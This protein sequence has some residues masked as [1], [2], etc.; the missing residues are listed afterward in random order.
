MAQFDWRSNSEEEAFR[1]LCSQNLVGACLL[2]LIF[3]GGLASCIPEGLKRN[4]E[5]K[6]HQHSHKE[7]AQ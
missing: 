3:F 6:A 5:C 4:A 1:K 7:P 2:A